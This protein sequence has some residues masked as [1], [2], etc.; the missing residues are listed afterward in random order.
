VELGTQVFKVLCS[1]QPFFNFFSQ[2]MEMCSPK[3]LG[4]KKPVCFCM[5]VYIHFN[6]YRKESIKYSCNLEHAILETCWP[7]V[8]SLSGWSHRGFKDLVPH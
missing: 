3:T 2:H 8:F 4:G 7:L 1:N 6:S 5:R